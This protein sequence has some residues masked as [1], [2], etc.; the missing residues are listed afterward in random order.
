M[1]QRCRLPILSLL[2]VM[3]LANA[4]AASVAKTNP[5]R[6]PTPTVTPELTPPPLTIKPARPLIWTAH[7]LPP[8]LKLT[9]YNWYGP[10]LAQ[11]DGETAYLCELANGQAQVWAT[12]DR[13]V[14]WTVAG[15]VPVASDVA[16]CYITV[17][18]LQ[19]R[20]ALLRTYAPDGQC[21]AKYTG[22][23][24]IYLTTDGGATWTPR[25]APA[26]ATP[27]FYE[28]VTLGGV[29][30]AVAGTR[31]HSRC[32]DCYGALYLSKDSMRTW[33]R[34]DGDIFVRNGYVSQRFVSTFWLGATGEL[35]TQVTNNSGASTY[36][37]WRSSDQGAHWSKMSMGRSGTVDTIVVGDGQGPRFWRACAAYQTLGDYTHP[38]VQQISCTLDGGKTWLDTGGSNSYHINIFAQAPDGALLAVTPNPYRGERATRL[39]RI[40]PGQSS[41]E[42]LGALSPA[43]GD[44]HTS[45][46]GPEVLWSVM[47]PAEYG[48]PLTTVYTAMYP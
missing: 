19:P 9:V 10:E 13:A 48:Q 20:Q 23:I 1:S 6:T 15:G 18:A 39:L 5:V 44:A 46:A 26:E 42:S 8:G 4:C 21:C 12:H 36:E 41:W 32:S 43:G 17:D 34:I 7:Q 22:E 37:L 27:L 3:L 40:V 29:S 45:G 11:S 35:L 30:Y 24:R 16:E 28:L 14:H 25:D 2:F 31:P 38:P 33:S 47:R